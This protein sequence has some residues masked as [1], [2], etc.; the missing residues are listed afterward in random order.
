MKK[1]SND[2]R[3]PL[4]LMRATVYD[5]NP[6]Q[7]EALRK[8]IRAFIQKYR[9]APAN[10]AY[11]L[12]SAGGN[13]EDL[14]RSINSKINLHRLSPQDQNELIELQKKIIELKNQISLKTAEKAL[15]K[16]LEALDDL[17]S[18][19]Q[20]A[21]NDLIG[22]WSNREKNIEL[23][24]QEKEALNTQYLNAFKEVSSENIRSLLLL[25]NKH[26]NNLDTLPIRLNDFG[27][28]DSELTAYFLKYRNDGL[29]LYSKELR[30]LKSFIGLDFFLGHSTNINLN[31]I[32]TLYSREVLLKRGI[33]FNKQNTQSQDIVYLSDTDFVFFYIYPDK[34]IANNSS[35]F[36]DKKIVI[37]VNKKYL[38]QLHV[39]M[40][41]D[42][43]GGIGGNSHI[44]Y[45]KPNR[46]YSKLIKD[47]AGDDSILARI[48]L[49]LHKDIQV[50][51]HEAV[52][53]HSF[54]GADI[55]KGIA[56]AII[57]LR[58]KYIC[59]VG[60]NIEAG[61][62]ALLNEVM[63]FDKSNPDDLRKLNAL[64]NGWIRPIIKIPTMVILS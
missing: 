3:N 42:D 15:Y 24:K 48:G 31:E 37:P 56:L 30:F 13:H 38:E 51:L 4:E 44:I 41:L 34:S 10:N 8:F 47:V 60:K 57:Y 33:E 58:R 23:F 7:R 11:R 28:L 43:Y 9:N 50:E 52:R 46:E 22:D 61:D 63:L 20:T 12:M 25:I 64:M 45:N 49:K 18:T 21:A 5:L 6:K 14:L 29:E 59:V 39:Y 32:S 55:L 62:M 19:A 54:V 27:S 16:D 40:T 35:R 26:K 36:G 53:Y 1:Y 17:L 2:F